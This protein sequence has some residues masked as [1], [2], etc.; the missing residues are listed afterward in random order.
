LGN[1]GGKGHFAWSVVGDIPN[2]ASRI[3]GL[4]K[5]LGT[6]MLASS[7]VTG[8][9]GELLTRRV[10]R[11]RLVG[12]ANAIDVH[13]LLALRDEAT[14]EQHSLADRFGE[15]LET[16][17]ASHLAEAAEMFDRILEDFPH[18]EPA[19]FHLELCQKHSTAIMAVDDAAIVRLEVKREGR[20][21]RKVNF[22]LN[23]TYLLI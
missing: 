16:C 14:P 21:M 23:V 11:F 22:S 15:A 19:R 4:N 1:V 2:T 17:E 9:F 12:K 13:E 3:E 7:T 10:G 18:D 5:H 8:D 6:R 20:H